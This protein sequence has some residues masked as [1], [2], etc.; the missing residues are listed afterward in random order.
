[1]AK[2]R[3]A[4]NVKVSIGDA[5]GLQF[6]P[7]RISLFDAGSGK[8]IPTALHDHAQAAEHAHV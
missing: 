2:A 4:A 7:D 5:V 6:R 8:A 1:M 3:L